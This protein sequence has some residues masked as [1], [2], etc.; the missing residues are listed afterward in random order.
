MPGLNT[1]LDNAIDPFGT[2]FLPLQ[3]DEHAAV[4]G[5][6]G[7]CDGG[8]ER[9]V[10]AEANMA[11]PF[12]N[13]D[14]IADYIRNG[15][16]IASG[17]QPRAF[18][19]DATKTITVDV[20]TLEA[21]GAKFA[22]IALK[23]WGEVTG[24]TFTEV[25][26]NAKISFTD[27]HIA[28]RTPQ[29]LDLRAFA[30]TT[31]Q[32]QAIV[33]SAITITDD[34]LRNYGPQNS[35]YA[36]QTYIHEVGHALGLGHAGNY[37][38]NAAYPANAGHVN[39]TWLTTVMS[40]F[41]QTDNTTVDASYALALTPMIADIIAV[42]AMYG[43]GTD[44]RNGN[45]VYGFASNAGDIYD[46]TTVS[47]L[48]AITIYDTGGIDTLNYS[49]Y[50]QD[51]VFN[52][53]WE[54]FSSYG[55]LKN[56]LVI[57]RGTLIE[58]VASGSG[59]DIITGIGI[60]NY[61][62]GGAGNDT[63]EGAGGADTLLG[64]LGLDTLSY[65]GSPGGVFVNLITNTASGSD[66][67]GDVISGFENLTGS[68][69][70]DYLVTGNITGNATITMIAGAGNDLVIMNASTVGNGGAGNDTLVLQ[71]VGNYVIG[72]AGDDTFIVYAAGSTL[73]ENAGEGTDL[74]FTTVDM[75]LGANIENGVNLAVGAA[76][77]VLNGNALDNLL[78]LSN[79]GATASSTV[80]AG[81]GNDTIYAQ[82]F[83]IIDAGAGNDV[84]SLS[85]TSNY[86]SGSLGDDVYIVNAGGQTLVEAAGAGNDTVYA[87]HQLHSGRELRDA[88]SGLQQSGHPAGRY[89]QFGGQ[90]DHRQ[91]R[92]QP[93][94]G[95]GW[96]RLSS[97]RAAAMTS[98]SAAPAS[99]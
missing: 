23:F 97:L 42:Q 98:S 54:S 92:G 8:T 58:N 84:I 53:A 82:S 66:A 59:N 64:G 38:G 99:T 60:A 24:I 73:V 6:S 62:D 26:G 81:A 35:S 28:D 91:W 65:A 87:D 79:A 15:S 85:G 89:R 41:S 19:L 16:W 52:L 39:D 22:R 72:G 61:L 43:A 93:A 51:Q 21:D 29:N 36:L 5:C 10:W 37:D 49:Q 47:D 34:W 68:A 14:Q 40:Y 56:N 80:N 70:D 33:S 94:F 12:L 83:A 45:T 18:V 63:I 46:L 30:A 96:R 76:G 2:G 13:N 86:V 20:S 69:F 55:G 32:G 1:T 9:P 90:P 31:T 67:Q 77:S 27:D 44:A 25:V 95:R 57:A 88:G 50:T 75:T 17:D 71:G 3:T 48:P 74:A 4:C 11:L 78:I 7:C